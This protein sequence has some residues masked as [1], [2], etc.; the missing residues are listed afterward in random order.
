MHDGHLR[1]VAA[2]TSLRRANFEIASRLI[3]ISALPGID[4]L[5]SWHSRTALSRINS[6]RRSVDASRTTARD[7]QR[8]MTACV[9]QKDG[10]TR[11]ERKATRPAADLIRFY[12]APGLYRQPGNVRK[13]IAKIFKLNARVVLPRKNSRCNQLIFK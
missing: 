6:Y 3:A 9:T 4:L 5:H 13:L 11:H 8:Q 2:V 12:S 10:H 7:V 1:I